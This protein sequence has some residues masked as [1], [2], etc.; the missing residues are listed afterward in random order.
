MTHREIH[1]SILLL[2]VLDEHFLPYPRP[3]HGSP[4]E[5]AKQE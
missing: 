1:L 3:V 2:D 5:F 4:G